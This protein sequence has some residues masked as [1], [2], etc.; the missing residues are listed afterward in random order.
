MGSARIGKALGIQ[1]STRA[2]LADWLSQGLIRQL[3]FAQMMG[4]GCIS[5]SGMKCIYCAN[6]FKEKADLLVGL[7]K[8]VSI[9][10]TCS[11]IAKEEQA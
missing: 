5:F 8:E 10:V 7:W 4:H 1:D 3:V 6:S 9:S 11:S 2:T